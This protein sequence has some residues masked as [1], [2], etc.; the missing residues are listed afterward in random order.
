MRLNVL[1][2]QL[3]LTSISIVAFL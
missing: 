2:S 3:V 1:T